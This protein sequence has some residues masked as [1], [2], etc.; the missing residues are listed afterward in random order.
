MIQFKIGDQIRAVDISEPYGYGNNVSLTQ[1]RTYTVEN[2]SNRYLGQ[3]VSITD[4][5]GES[6]REWFADRFELVSEEASLSLL[7]VLEQ[8]IADAYSDHDPEV[9]LNLTEILE[10]AGYDVTTQVEVTAT[11]REKDV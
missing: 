3:V 1:G 2:T 11:K 9:V 5:T 4:D 8:R 10:E 6:G 7:N